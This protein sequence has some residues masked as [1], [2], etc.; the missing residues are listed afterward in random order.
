M[1]AFA[2]LPRRPLAFQL[3]VV[4]LVLVLLFICYAKGEPPSWRWGDRK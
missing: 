2:F 1:A 3:T 4:G